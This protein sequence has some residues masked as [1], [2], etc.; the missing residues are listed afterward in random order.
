MAIYNDRKQDLLSYAIKY[1]SEYVNM[2]DLEQIVDELIVK[3]LSVKQ[4]RRKLK[5]TRQIEKYLFG[6]LRQNIILK[7]HVEKY[8]QTKQRIPIDN[9]PFWNRNLEVYKQVFNK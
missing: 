2:V 1:K 5:T 6:S 4:S 8:H 7:Y 9:S 3:V